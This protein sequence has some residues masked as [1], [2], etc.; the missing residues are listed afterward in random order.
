MYGKHLTPPIEPD[1]WLA[2]VPDDHRAQLEALDARIRALAPDLDRYVDHGF[3]SYGRYHYRGRSGREGD[4]M[5]IALAS[6]KG[7]MSLYISP[8]GTA[9]FADRLP[10]SSIGRGCIRFKRLDD[11]DPALLDEIITTAATSDGT[12]FHGDAA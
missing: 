2:A 3:L 10:A 5:P 1:A 11:L 9:P 7:F 6:N 12:F 8:V 4:W